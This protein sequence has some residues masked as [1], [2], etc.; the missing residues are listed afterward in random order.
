MSFDDVT[1]PDL[2][3]ADTAVIP[4]LGS[5]VTTDGPTMRATVLE[6]RVFLLETEPR[7]MAF[8][9]FEDL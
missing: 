5:R 2:V 9:L 3:S 1:T 6:E 7:L 4:A 8:V